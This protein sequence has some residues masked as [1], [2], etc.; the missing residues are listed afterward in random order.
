MISI[1]VIPVSSRLVL[2][3]RAWCVEV[4]QVCGG[5]QVPGL[6]K[7][8]SACDLLQS[9]SRQC[10][11]KETPDGKDCFYGNG[12]NYQ[13]DRA[14]S[15]SGELCQTWSDAARLVT[16]SLREE[17]YSWANLQGSYCRNPYSSAEPWCYV[18]DSQDLLVSATCAVD[19]CEGACESPANPENGRRVPMK[20]AY[21][22]G[23]RVSFRCNEGYRITSG[24]QDAYCQQNGTWTSSPPECK[25]DGRAR[26]TEELFDPDFYNPAFPPVGSITIFF[27]AALENVIQLI[28][29]DGQILSSVIFRLIWNDS[30]LRWQNSRYPDVT[31]IRVAE[32]RLWRPA[33]ALVNN[34]DPLFEGFHSTSGAR[35]FQNGEVVW[36]ISQLLKTTCSLNARNFPFDEMECST[37]IADEELQNSELLRCLGR[38][39]RP[40]HSSRID[41]VYC[42]METTTK[43]R[44][45]QWD[46]EWEVEGEEKGNYTQACIKLHM[47]RDPTFHMCTTIGPSVFLALLMAVTFLLPLDTGERLGYAMT[48]FLAMVVTLVFITDIVPTGKFLPVVAVIVLIYLCMMAIWMLLAFFSIKLSQKEGTLPRWARAL[49]LRHLARMLLLGDLSKNRGDEKEP[50]IVS[51]D[52][53][54]KSILHSEKFEQSV[55]Y[56]FHD[57]PAEK[58]KLQI[59][60]AIK[61]I[62]TELQASVK[63]LREKAEENS[64]EEEEPETDYYNLAQVLDRICF[65]TYIV[66]LVIA[67]PLTG[68]YSP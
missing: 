20:G 10:H 29:Q 30:R 50:K 24:E 57:K 32:N 36:D 42:D 12:E 13:G 8:F 22:T 68:L 66:G 54:D 40:V 48:I 38:D 1:F 27:R 51:V 2:P 9:N 31:E 17:R 19:P 25:T 18:K 14:F 33:L 5:G 59:L 34:A 6:E 4:Q 37:C 35:I 60:H 15:S 39:H 56:Y 11:S 61:Q 52:S 41:L 23:D 44:V 46:T 28:E 49:F 3:C 64:K 47:R 67:I 62:L 16:P 58:E 55:V 7:T 63:S 45:D 43:I 21:R 53:T 26:L 65:V